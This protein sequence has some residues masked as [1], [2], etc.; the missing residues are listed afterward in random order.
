M[1][2]FRAFL[3]AISLL[4]LS[5]SPRKDAS[6]IRSETVVIGIANDFNHLNPLLIQFSLSREVCMLLFP[7]L[8][9]ADLDA[10]SGEVRF[11]PSLATRWEFSSDGKRATFFL[12]SDAKWQDGVP[13]T[14]ADLK[15]S[16]RLYA[17]PAVASTRQ[18]YVGDLV[19]DQNGAID[20][21]TGVQTPNDT[22]LVL[23]F[24][25]PLAPNVVLDHF[26]DLMPVPKHVFR[27]D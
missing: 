12:R 13:I 22:T 24:S 18:H 7:K 25:R 1:R 15:F 20:F 11:L 14:A 9:Q 8:V 5:C 27:E 4:S 23:N 6:S 19:R 3:L 17:E 2:A 16:Y 21:E 10:T 26:H